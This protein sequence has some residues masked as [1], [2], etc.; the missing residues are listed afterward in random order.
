MASAKEDL[1]YERT[2][3]IKEEDCERL[4]PEEVCMKLEDHE[5]I[6]SVFKEEEEYKG[7]TAA[8]KAEDLN[9][10]SVGL[11]LQKHETED[12][13]KKDACEESPSSLK[14]WS[15]NTGRL[16]TQENSAELKTELS[17]SEEKITEGNEREGE[18][19]PG[20]VG[21][22]LQKNGSFSPPSFGQHSL[23][24]NE[25]GM[26]KSARGSENLTAA[27]LQC[28]SYPATGVTQ[29]ETIK[30]D[31]QQVEK[32]IQI[33][34]G[35][36]CCLESGKQ[37][38]HKSDLNEH[39][40]I[41]N[42]ENT[43]CC[44]ECGMSFSRKSSLQRHRRIHTGEKPH[45]C[46]E[47][48][49]SFSCISDLQ[50]HRRSHTGEKPH[51]EVAALKHHKLV[52][53]DRNL[54]EELCVKH[55]KS[56]EMFCKT[57]EMC[58]CRM[59]VMAE[60]DGYEKVELKME[61]E[62]KQ[63]QLGATQS[64]IRRRL[65]EKEKKLRETRKTAEE[66]K[67][68]VER[69]MGKHEKSFTDLIHC[70]EE[71]YKN[72]TE[73]IREQEKREIEKAKT[74]MEQLEKEI[75]ELKR[76]EAELKEL[77]ETKDHLHFLQSFSSRCVLP[78][79]GDSLSFTVTANFSSEDLLKELSCLKKSLKKISQWDILTWTP[80]GREAPIFTLRHPEPQNR[81]EFLQY[82][83]PLTLDINTAHRHLHLSE[84]NK[85]VTCEGTKAEYPD[86]PDRFD[87]CV[88]VLCREALTGTRCYWEVECSG[89]FMKIGVAY[90][91]LDRKGGV[92]ECGLGYNDKSWSLVWS[93]S[94][95][96]VRHNKKR[97]VIG[98]PFSP[99]IGVYLDWPAGSLSFYSVSHTMTLLHRFNTSFTEPL[100][101]GP[102]KSA[103]CGPCGEKFGD[104]CRPTKRQ[105]KQHLTVNSLTTQ[106]KT[107]KRRG[108]AADHE[109][110][111]CPLCVWKALIG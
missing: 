70:I 35:K 57:D 49:E 32:E 2:V 100:Y 9:D 89:R 78:A 44:H 7:V 62:G 72:L 20:S 80:P 75:E 82:F 69:V 106:Y 81:E 25:K 93:L 68:S 105:L 60:H 46:P 31:R 22:N 110:S 107:M 111:R 86:H 71:T 55:Q 91:G 37:F 95:Y 14:P 51:Y 79:D 47:C 41:H 99:R 97:T 61:R 11:E 18:E 108:R 27:F 12:I 39:M 5:E 43:Y 45:C 56:L 94:Q 58:V 85:K 21:I 73:K 42:G 84:G 30:T 8:I 59:C 66:M 1:V 17:E 34:T 26:K 63:K 13:F 83:C 36:K 76:R 74:V 92:W 50:N 77:S 53:P 64:E 102:L 48:G 98:A 67:L 52:D 6:I 65:E 54:K 3:D 104:P 28:S 19:S 109:G 101:P 10:F 23:Q 38:T 29:T 88:Q 103:E 16:A 87:H 24:Y 4:T 15:T 40:K 90:K 96:S 33:H